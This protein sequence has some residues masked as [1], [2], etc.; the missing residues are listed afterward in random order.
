MATIVETSQRELH[1]FISE[2]SEQADS[3]NYGA[4]G[5]TTD[6][7][8][9]TLRK[10]QIENFFPTLFLSRGVPMLLGGDEFR[11]TQ[12]G[13]NNAYCQDNETSWVDW[14]DLERHQKNYR[15]A[16]GMIAFRRAHPILSV[17]K[18][19][20]DAEIHWFGPQG[21]L[22][23]WRGPK[24]K[25]FARVIKE[26]RPGSLLIMFKAGMNG[27][28]FAFPPLPQ[29]F[30]WRLEADTSRSAPQDLFTAG[31]EMA[32]DSSKPYNLEARSSA[33]FVAR[34]KVA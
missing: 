7:A 4:E 28:G 11:R 22:P 1:D 32:V 25:T 15:F 2:I 5:E 6:A 8:I 17:E 13:N 29:G 21:A 9:E 31:E 20:A 27:T 3:E 19:Y 23:N 33:I 26:S 18:F 12:G 10:R 24:E 34:K 16:Q 14:G 30:Q